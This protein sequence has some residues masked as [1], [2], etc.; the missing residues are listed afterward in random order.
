MEMTVAGCRRRVVGLRR[1]VGMAGLATLMGCQAAVA[2]P[3]TAGER[4]AARAIVTERAPAVVVVLATI[5]VRLNV[6]GREQTSDQTA[7]TN[8]TVLDPS[9]LAVMSLQQIQPDEAMTRMYS[10]Q[11]PGGARVEVT[12]DIAD[13]R[14]HLADGRELPAKLVLRDEDLDLAFVRPTE[15]L[16]AP[17]PFVDATS[18]RPQL[19]DALTLVRRT[20]E[21]T[22][23]APAAAFATVELVIDKPR[24]YYQVV[25]LGGG[26]PG[27]P[28]FDAAGHFV[29]VLV[30]R[31]TGT[32]GTGA[33][34]VLP[35]DD[36][37]DVAKQAPPK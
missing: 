25:I 3:Q 7:Q 2:A 8:A 6:S 20:G 29:G 15:P 24:T 10:R 31:D 17:L 14:M 21:P 34:G 36:I 37:R 1:V 11:A 4:A 32:R 23:W 28:L 16:S 18:A 9:G 5:K 12:T 26:G 27:C 22:A 35:A 30:M 13:M 19:L 33:L